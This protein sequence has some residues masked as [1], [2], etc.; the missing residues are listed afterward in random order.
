MG[1]SSGGREREGRVLESK[2]RRACVQ[3]SFRVAVDGRLNGC[4][5]RGGRCRRIVF[6]GEL[7]V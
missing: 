6:V 2:V 5:F 7:V 1:L 3:G 4:S